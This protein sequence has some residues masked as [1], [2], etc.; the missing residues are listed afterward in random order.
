[1]E[2]ENISGQIPKKRGGIFTFL[3]GLMSVLI[4]FGTLAGV[5]YYFFIFKQELKHQETD[6]GV[7]ETVEV[8][9]LV[10]QIKVKNSQIKVLQ[11]ENALLRGEVSNITQRL[12]YAIKPKAQ[13]VSECYEARIGDWKLPQKCFNEL[14][15][16]LTQLL[17]SDKRIL[18]LEVIGVVDEKKYA[19]RSP[20]LKQEGLASFRAKNVI[21][22]LRRDFPQIV[23]F[24][25]LSLQQPQKRGFAVRA[26][27]VK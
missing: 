2:T 11:D 14:N 26:Y 22:R 21:E 18:V 12:K 25:G 4:L 8:K 7:F 13:F 10:E 6:S 19:G 23:T 16:N 15:R 1:M 3:L 27:Y 20:E 5:A 9:K 24:E 17:Q